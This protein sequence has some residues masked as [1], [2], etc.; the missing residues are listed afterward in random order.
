M[1]KKN[2]IRATLQEH[3]HWHDDSNTFIGFEYLQI[4]SRDIFSTRNRYNVWPQRSWMYACL[5]Q[6]EELRNH[7]KRGLSVAHQR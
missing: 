4:F 2:E 1:F 6:S 7:L 5:L 3:V